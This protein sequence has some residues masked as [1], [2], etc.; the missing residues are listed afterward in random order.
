MVAL[1]PAT[2]AMITKYGR[3]TEPEFLPVTCRLERTR[4]HP[5]PPELRSAF[6]S[7]TEPS[8]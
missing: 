1:F 8:G 4:R 2:S 5:R 3:R 7:V 6:R